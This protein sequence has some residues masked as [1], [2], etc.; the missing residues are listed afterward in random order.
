MDWN[1]GDEFDE[2]WKILIKMMEELDKEFFTDPEEFFMKPIGEYYQNHRPTRIEI[3]TINTDP[4]FLYNNQPIT[5]KS[6]SDIYRSSQVKQ[7]NG[8]ILDK[9]DKVEIVVDL[10]Y[11]PRG[12]YQY[13]EYDSLH[14]W[15]VFEDKT[16]K[17]RTVIRLPDDIKKYQISPEPEKAIYNN[18]IFYA[19]FKKKKSKFKL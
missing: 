2:I 13:H 9:G 6:L 18:G 3:W 11:L 16:T 5:R 8:E 17:K 15:L 12:S 14:N 1:G 10:R 19:V 7:Q 4:N